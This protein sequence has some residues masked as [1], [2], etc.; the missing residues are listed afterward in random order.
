M[1]YFD[2]RKQATKKKQE[3]ADSQFAFWPLTSDLST[4]ADHLHSDVLQVAV[5]RR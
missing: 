2:N 1:F 5:Y 4:S 3:A